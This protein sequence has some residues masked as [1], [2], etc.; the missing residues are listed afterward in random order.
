MIGSGS[1][2]REIVADNLRAGRHGFSRPQQYEFARL[3][4]DYTILSKRRLLALVKEGHV[5]GWDDQRMST[6]AAIRRRGVG[7]RAV[8]AFADL[9]GRR[10]GQLDGRHRQAGFLHAGGPQLDR[11]PN[12]RGPSPA[13]GHD[14]IVARRQHRAANLVGG[15]AAVAPAIPTTL[16]P[17]PAR[18]PSNG[19]SKV[20]TPA[21]GRGRAISGVGLRKRRGVHSVWG[22]RGSPSF[23][24]YQKGGH[25]PGAS[26]RVDVVGAAA[27]CA[28]AEGRMAGR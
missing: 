23:S 5:D 21:V 11:S 28:P 9:V 1:G 3:N 20:N 17:R 16:R 14:H 26:W 22:L 6:I 12:A 24:R 4:L 10:Q 25:G 18:L 7:L 2:I 15:N 8:Q 13:R 19:R 27:S